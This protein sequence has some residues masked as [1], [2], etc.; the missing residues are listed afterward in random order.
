MIVLLLASLVAAQQPPTDGRGVLERMHSAYAGRWYTSIAFVQ[1]T[2]LVRAGG[3]R[4]TATW[5]ESLK[6]PDLLRIDFGDPAA[7]RGVIFTAE[8]LFAFR[9]GRLARAGTEGNPFLPL[10]MG[11]YLQPV[12][13]TVRG[14]AHHGF[15]LAK[16]YSSTWEGRPV[17]VVG[18]ATAGDSTAAQF[19]VDA[20]R[21]IVVRMRVSSGAGGAPLDIRVDDYQPVGGGWLG[22]RVTISRDGA[23]VQVEEYTEWS[24]AVAVPDS[25]FERQRWVTGGH[26]ASAARPATLWKRRQGD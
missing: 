6:G 14:A 4:D 22:T 15:D 8:S 3:Q 11:V 24:T 7:R 16:M 17:Y 21:L 5:Y 26:W 20:D 23:P 1:K 19:W 13:A 2:T 12:D 10:V 18:A 9:E 25:L